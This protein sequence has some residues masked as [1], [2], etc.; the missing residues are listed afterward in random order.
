LEINEK[1]TKN[2]TISDYSDIMQTCTTEMVASD[3]TEGDPV[4]VYDYIFIF[5][6][7]PEREMTQ[8]DVLSYLAVSNTLHTVSLARKG[9]FKSGAVGVNK[10][11]GVMKSIV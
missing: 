5:F 4:A 2:R 1:Q 9:W 7:F 11:N 3:R 8:D 10:L 6:F